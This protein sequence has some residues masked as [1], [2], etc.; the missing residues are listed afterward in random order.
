M[1][2][3]QKYSPLW[4]KVQKYKSINM[5]I[6]EWEEEKEKLNETRKT[7]E[8]Q[9]KGKMGIKKDKKMPNDATIESPNLKA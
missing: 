5:W 3:Y 2:A 7:V 4:G 1:H 8:L 6:F 9:E